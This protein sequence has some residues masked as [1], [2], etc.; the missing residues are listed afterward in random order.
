MSPESIWKRKKKHDWYAEINIDYLQFLKLKGGEGTLW[1][2]KEGLKGEF[3]WG[4]WRVEVW[5][6]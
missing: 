1:E 4:Q 6:Q 3:F 5:Q 2:K